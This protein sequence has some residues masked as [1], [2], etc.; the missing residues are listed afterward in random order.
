[1]SHP[2]IK[3]LVLDVLKPHSPSLP[4]FATY[5]CDLEYVDIVDISLVE[6]DE[7]TESLKVVIHGKA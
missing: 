2:E 7:E 1:M 3:E 6:I 5:L 4:E